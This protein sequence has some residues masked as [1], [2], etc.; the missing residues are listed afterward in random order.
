MKVS[1]F[2]KHGL[3]LA[4]TVSVANLGLQAA[5]LDISIINPNR[6]GGPGSS[7]LFQGA[8]TNNTEA[9]LNST[10]LFLNFSGFDPLNVTLTQLLGSTNFSI[11]IGSTSP[12]VDL[13]TF[14]LA[15]TASIPATYP[16]Q[17]VLQA[18]TGDIA[19]TQTVT[20]STTVPEPGSL[21]L[22]GLGGLA[23]LLGALRKRAR[24]LLMITAVIVIAPAVIMAQVSAVQFVTSKPG[25]AEISQTLM[26]AL[27]IANNGTVTATNVQVTGATLR[28]A[29]LVTPTTFPV[30][31]GTIAPG[32]SVTFQASFNATSLA[33][34]TS[35]LLTVSGTYQVGTTTAGF[36]VNRFIVIPPASP[37][38]AT[39]QTTTVGSV[40]VSGAPFPHQP[41]N[42]PDDV[43]ESV[44][45][46]PTG[47]FVPGI[48][49][50]GTQSAE[51]PSISGVGSLLGVQPLAAVTFNLN[52]G[53]GLTSGSTNGT[54]S[55]VAEPSGATN[56]NRVV[57]T[58]ANWTAAY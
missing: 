30:V 41:L 15:N 44:P 53:L 40:S 37:G 43:N 21:A 35:Y 42:F 55:T 2:P 1:H 11:A 23:L 28:T 49:S 20:V 13:F 54:A 38:S 33:T 36:A 6:I 18:V 10:D 14:D 25:L 16:A 5:A 22:V 56:G 19:D 26:V 31:L 32:N 50:A 47:P 45:P 34:D 58:S 12:V 27:P 24:P 57:F 9:A 7:H 29:P 51:V 3:A 17:V 8:I 52:T 39:L 46:V 48:P 4:I